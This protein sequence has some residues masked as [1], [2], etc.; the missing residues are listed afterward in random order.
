[1]SDRYPE[2]LIVLTRNRQLKRLGS[3][4]RRFKGY[5]IAQK[6]LDNNKKI[7]GS[8]LKQNIHI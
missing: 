7:Q 2:N 3:F 4:K 8:L 5:T 6:A 1:M